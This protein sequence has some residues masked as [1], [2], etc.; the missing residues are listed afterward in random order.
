MEV[1]GF[2]PDQCKLVLNLQM[3]TSWSWETRRV[4]FQRIANLWHAPKSTMVYQIQKLGKVTEIHCA[5]F[6]W[7]LDQ[8]SVIH[9]PLCWA[10]F[11]TNIPTQPHWTAQLLWSGYPCWC[12]LWGQRWLAPSRTS[13][14]VTPE[15]WAV[16]VISHQP[17]SL[18][19]YSWHLGAPQTTG[20]HDFACDEARSEQEKSTAFTIT[21]PIIFPIISC[22]PPCFPCLP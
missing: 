18:W 6:N 16:L 22:P 5:M 20:S 17:Q 11:F 15:C 9:R 3:S 7:N 8:P 21:W 4:C 19:S 10:A 13:D 12:Y 2:C 1:W 14:T